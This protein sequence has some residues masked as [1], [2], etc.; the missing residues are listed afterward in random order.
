MPVGGTVGGDL[1]G[2]P[3]VGDDVYADSPLLMA[4]SNLSG[5]GPWSLLQAVSGPVG[6]RVGR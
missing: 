1:R 5:E 6:M 3:S 2:V 4:S